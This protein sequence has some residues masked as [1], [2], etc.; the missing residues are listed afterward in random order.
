MPDKMDPQA[1][2]E[3]AERTAAKD[4]P[5][6][7]DPLGN[8]IVSVLAAPFVGAAEGVELAVAAKA[9]VVAE[10]VIAAGEIVHEIVH[11]HQGAHPAEQSHEGTG[12][13]APSAEQHGADFTHADQGGAADHQDANACY[14]PAQDATN[15]A[16]ADQGGAADHQDANACYN[17]AQDATNIAHADQGGAVDH[18]D[19]NACYNPA[20]DGATHS[21][22]AN[23][24]DQGHHGDINAA[25]A[26]HA[27]ADHSQMADAHH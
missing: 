24:Q 12:G 13:A 20:Q 22:H 5:I 8:L 26:D 4:K 14:N 25:P 21:D 7:S 27:S 1:Q 6:Q 15:I 10:G 16:H 11:H 23:A 17:P 9:H 19:A 3:A 18:Q 2:K